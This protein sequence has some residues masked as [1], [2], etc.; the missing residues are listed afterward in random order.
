MIL[1]RI[2]KSFKENKNELNINRFF[3]LLKES[4]FLANVALTHLD[5]I[6]EIIEKNIFRPLLI[7]KITAKNLEI[8]IEDDV[9]K[10][11]I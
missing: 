11:L 4:K 5:L 8:G 7:L 6:K 10:L 1:I 9:F 2:L 3:V